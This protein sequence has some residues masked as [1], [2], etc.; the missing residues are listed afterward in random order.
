MYWSPGTIEGYLPWDWVETHYLVQGSI[1]PSTSLV[2]RIWTE[3]YRGIQ[4][5]NIY[6]ANVDKCQPMGDTEK[7]WTKAECRA[8]RAYFYLN[9]VKEFGPVPLV[10][11]RVYNVDDPLSSMLLPRSSVDE[12]YDYISVSLRMY[13]KEET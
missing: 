12:C 6:L 4:Y 5:A 8:L 13:F 3:Y 9:L 11:D 1:D 7:A 10:G 2:N